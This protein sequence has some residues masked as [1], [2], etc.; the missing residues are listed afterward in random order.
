MRRNP[1]CK[2]NGETLSDH[3][4]VKLKKY[5]GEWKINCLGKKMWFF[6]FIIIKKKRK[7]YGRLYLLYK[8]NK[9]IFRSYRIMFSEMWK[10]S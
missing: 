6:S 1:F 9:Q 8:S 2:Y 7:N 5:L 4:I 3:Q 10:L